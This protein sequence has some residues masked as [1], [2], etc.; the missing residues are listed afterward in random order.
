MM[1]FLPCMNVPAGTAQVKAS[2]QSLL[3]TAWEADKQLS[4]ERYRGEV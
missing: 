1:Y 2:S 3:V 4:K